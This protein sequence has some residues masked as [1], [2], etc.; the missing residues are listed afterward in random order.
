MGTRRDGVLAAVASLAVSCGGGS[1]E[2]STSSVS[3]PPPRTYACTGSVPLN[4]TLCPGADADLVADAPRVVIGSTCP[5]TASCAVTPCSYVCNGGFVV[6]DDGTCIATTVSPPS[7]AD[8]GDGT[9]TVSDRLGTS[10]WLRDAS[11][12]DTIA[13]VGANGVAWLDASSW[14]SH[15]ADGACG[16]RD[17][18][19]AG[20]WTLPSAAQLTQLSADLST[21]NP[22]VGVATTP[23][24][25]STSTCIN[26]YGAVEMGTG[27][28]L[29]YPSDMSFNVW[30]V[31]P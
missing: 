22:F 16:L 7:F 2:A 15:L 1:G 23:Y 21:A 18:S 12:P 31:R 4:A 14:A 3:P 17:G 27:T 5:C 30:P 11:C 25:S 6:T 24:W 20:A 13:G 8:N 9:V 26:V 29:D 10:T 19:A 28:Y